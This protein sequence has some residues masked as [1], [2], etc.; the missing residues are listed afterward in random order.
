VC[1]LS[2]SKEATDTEDVL[3]QIVEEN[4]ERR[5]SWGHLYKG[6]ALNVVPV[7][8]VPQG[9]ASTKRHTLAVA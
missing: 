6:K 1:S 4:I 5:I 9:F 3:E 2:H 7:P 8:F